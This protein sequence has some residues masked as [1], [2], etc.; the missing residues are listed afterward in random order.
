MQEFQFTANTP[1][2]ERGT[3]VASGAAL[4]GV[5]LAMFVIF[6]WLLPNLLPSRVLFWVVVVVPAF[7][8]FSVV[9]RR[10]QKRTMGEYILRL[11]GRHLTVIC[12]NQIVLDLGEVQR[13]SMNRHSNGK[14]ADFAIAGSKDQIKLRLRNATLWNG[15]SKERDFR[16]LAKAA[17]AIE[18]ALIH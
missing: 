8:V 3:A 2:G 5:M 6:A 16:T 12:P 13:T 18:D 10:M 11:D 1:A 9:A 15:K 14:C 4:V 7:V 17:S